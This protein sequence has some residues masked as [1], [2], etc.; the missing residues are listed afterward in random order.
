[1]LVRWTHPVYGP[2]APCD[3]VPLAERTQIIGEMTLYLIGHAVEQCRQ[4]SEH[5]LQAE[6]AINVSAND[7]IDPRV[8]A[9]ILD[10]V[11]HR[12]GCLVLEITETAVMRDAERTLAAIAALRAQGLRVSLDDFGTGNA[13][14]TYLRQLRPDEVKIDRSFIAAVLESP[15]DQ[16]IVRSTISLAHS[17]GAK[18][19]AEGVEDAATLD[20]LRRAGADAA[21]GFGLARPESPE[22][23][24]AR[25]R[26]SRSDAA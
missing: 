23:F 10:R 5:G 18:V 7:L 3:F 8:V 11:R 14:L 21:Q 15:A 17:L 20:W 26:R 25:L 2:L 22:Q 24:F 4:W 13:S 16:A 1:M 6:L 12:A 19:T 9:G